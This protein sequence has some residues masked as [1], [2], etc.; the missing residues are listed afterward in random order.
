M[1]FRSHWPGSVQ[2]SGAVCT[3]VMLNL[4]VF[5]ATHA[6]S[7]N[8]ETASNF[9]TEI[10]GHGTRGI[11][12]PSSSV[13]PN[14]QDPGSVQLVGSFGRAAISNLFDFTHDSFSKPWV[15]SKLSIAIIGHFGRGSEIKTS[16]STSNSQRGASVQVA[17]ICRGVI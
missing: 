8:P 11:G 13:T 15:T 5:P 10:I 4:F 16:N 3:D 9:F 14:S 7:L 1:L 17:A 2:P 12:M 6:E